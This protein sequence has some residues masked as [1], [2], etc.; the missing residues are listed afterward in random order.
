[1][2]QGDKFI[3]I[4][5]ST[6]AFEIGEKVTYTGFKDRLYP[7]LYWCY[8]ADNVEQIIDISQLTPIIIQRFPADDEQPNN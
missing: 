6:T 3:V 8:N 7:T 4:D 2:K 5:N 1:M